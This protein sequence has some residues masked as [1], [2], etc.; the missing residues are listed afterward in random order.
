MPWVL[1]LGWMRDDRHTWAPTIDTSFNRFNGN[2][3][4]CGAKNRPQVA[5]VKGEISIYA[6]LVTMSF[7]KIEAKWAS[8]RLT[9]S[10]PLS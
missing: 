9:N 7:N 4:C 1:A 2:G 8:E 6:S 3:I 10:V 5:K